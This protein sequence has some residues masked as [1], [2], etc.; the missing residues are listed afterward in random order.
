MDIHC[1]LLRLNKADFSL[2]EEKAEALVRKS[3]ND[4]LK[5]KRG[6]HYL[7]MKYPYLSVSQAIDE[8]IKNALW[9]DSII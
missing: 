3:C 4:F 2:S 7:M 1:K 6:F 9:I 8:Y 5:T